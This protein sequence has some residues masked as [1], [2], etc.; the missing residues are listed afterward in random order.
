MVTFCIALL[1]LVL[2]YVIYGAVV[3]KIFGADSSRK[4][5][6]YTMADG[7]DYC[8]KVTVAD[9]GIYAEERG[10]E[11]WEGKDVANFFPK[12]RSN[13]HKGSYGSA[14]ILAG[15][16]FSGAAFLAAGACLKSGA[17]YTKLC[18]SESLFP[19]AVGKLPAVVLRQFKAID[20]D[21]LGA[22]C[23]AAGMGSGVSEKLY[24]HLAELL[25]TYTGTLVLD[26]DALNTIAAYGTEVLDKKLC[27]VI[28][29][30]HPKE[31]VR[32]AGKPCAE[33]LSDAVNEAKRF[34]SQWNVTLILKNN[35]SG[36]DIYAILLL[37]FFREPRIY[38][39]LIKKKGAFIKNY[40]IER[41]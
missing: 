13:T 14:C 7:V 26:A 24:V 37:L 17:G 23:I 20:G 2:G 41:C 16:A 8:G 27:K 30:P 28:L 18:V 31:F 33:I 39:F 34:A 35:R 25:S 19:Y 38:H 40:L 29:T 3:E 21:I 1:L 5:P 11:I 15:G 32:L 4:T 12:R 22:D 6:C 10:A 9:I 36:K